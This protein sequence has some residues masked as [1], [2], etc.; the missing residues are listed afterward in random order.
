MSE[1]PWG[2]LAEAAQA[3]AD[4]EHCSQLDM[5]QLCAALD[6]FSSAIMGEHEGALDTLAGARA[7]ATEQAEDEGLWFV[8]QT[9]SEAYLQQELRRLTRAVEE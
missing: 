6:K 1:Y 7:V 2:L 9:I 8:P 5:R 4:S 3:V